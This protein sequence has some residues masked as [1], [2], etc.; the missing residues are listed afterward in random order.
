MPVRA[1][2]SEVKRWYDLRFKFDPAAHLVA[3]PASDSIG[4]ESVPDVTGEAPASEQIASVLPKSPE[5]I[6]ERI[7]TPTPK[8]S[9]AEQAERALRRPKQLIYC[10]ISNRHFFWRQHITKFVLDE[11]H[12]PIVPFMLFDYYLL[13]TVPKEVVREACNNLIVRSDQ[14]WVFGHMSLGVKVQIGIAKRLKKPVRFYDVTDM[15]YRLVN[16]PE[17]MLREE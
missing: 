8:A 16:V 17:A 3:M 2:E 10:A 13:H 1:P 6:L 15:P 9:P 11:G 14:M 12:V 5:D 7:F 4:G